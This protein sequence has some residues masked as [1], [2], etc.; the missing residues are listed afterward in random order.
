M[1]NI[2][3]SL[4]KA[5]S[6]K[7]VLI[8]FIATMAIYL[9]MLFYTI[10]M[11]ENFAPNTALFDLSPSGYSYQHAMSLLERL[12][13]SGRTM[14]LTRQ[15]PLDF[16]YPGLFAASYTLLLI[17]LFSKSFK[18]TSR[19][20]YLSFIPALGGLF[21][22]LENIYI[23]SMLNSFPDLST[24]LVQVASTFTL[25]KS[26]FTTVFFLLLFIGFAAFVFTKTKTKLVSVNN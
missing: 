18:D 23:I 1:T 17:W 21:D 4:K 19:V 22:Y 2:L 15:L 10:P 26:I 5:A 14:Y 12:G 3:H 24:G 25:L 13:D 20:F 6:G 9:L 16:I 7:T 11:V 8:L